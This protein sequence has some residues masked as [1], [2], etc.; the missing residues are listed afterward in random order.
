[1]TRRN[2]RTNATS[3]RP[4]ARDVR[5][6]LLIRAAFSLTLAIAAGT[7][8][9]AQHLAPFDG[10]H[11]PPS[12]TDLT[13]TTPL[14]F[15]MTAAEASVALRTPLAYVQ[16]R[17]GDEIFLAVRHVGGSGYFPRDDRL[18]LQFRS[19]RLTGWKAYW[20]RDWLWR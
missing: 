11:P 9:Q 6:N 3:P 8:A 16:G 2:A 19:G 10:R 7:A 5:K 17:P 1:M 12:R 14:V 4:A 18:F 20:G 15:G 13:N